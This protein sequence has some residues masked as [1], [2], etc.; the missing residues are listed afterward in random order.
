MER[1]KFIH[2]SI[3]ATGGVAAAG[4]SGLGGN[5]DGD[6]NGNS[7][8]NG[9]GTGGSQF[10]S[11]D[12]PAYSDWPPA[13]PRTNDYVLFTHAN[14]AH[15]HAGSGEGTATP[16]PTPTPTGE[17]RSDFP[18]VD[19]PGYG[20]FV[21]ALW[22]Q[23]GMWSYPWNGDLG[24][25]TEPESMDTES[26]TMTEGTFVFHGEYDPSAFSERF[27]DGFEERETGDF[28]VFE[29][30]PG[31]G[32]DRL[33]YAV[34]EDAVVALIAPD[35]VANHDE[36]VGI[37]EN[38]ITNY[39]EEADRVADTEGG[40]RLHETTGEADFLLGAWQVDGLESDDIAPNASGGNASEQGQQSESSIDSS[41]AFEN[42][43]SLVNAV[44]LPESEDGVGGDTTA[45][46]FAAMYPE[47]EVPDAD[48]L[49]E[50]LAPETNP[51]DVTVTTTDARAYV[52]AEVTADEADATE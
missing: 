29:G 42:V 47:G 26:A 20:F 10:P 37:L 1:R 32:N 40:R 46:R 18:L 7:S 33:A 17:D 21:T 35:D 44:I 15:M 27:A 51:D 36:A 41:P 16:T 28:R 23:L 43:E 39:V 22:Y 12:V 49:R 30:Q 3:A 19:I 45:A 2:M 8:D 52:E 24:G 11:Y 5:G 48:T 38:A 13:S 50:E 9:S 25:E 6:G 4:C 31:E 14:M 34:S